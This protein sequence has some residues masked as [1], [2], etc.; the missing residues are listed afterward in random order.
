MITVDQALHASDIAK[1]IL[2]NT[3]PMC[4]IFALNVSNINNIFIILAITILIVAYF[5]I[6]Y[7][8]KNPNKDFT[9]NFRTIWLPVTIIFVVISFLYYKS[10]ISSD[11]YIGAFFIAT[12]FPAQFLFLYELRKMQHIDS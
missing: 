6:R 9:I 12:C 5:Y 7:G 11:A 8:I 2:I 10:L 4:V 3:I 1:T